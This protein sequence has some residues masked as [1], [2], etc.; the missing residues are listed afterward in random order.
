MKYNERQCEYNGSING[1]E[2]ESLYMSSN[3]KKPQ[4]NEEIE[5]EKIKL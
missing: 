5:E 4:F 1:N 2:H 3:V